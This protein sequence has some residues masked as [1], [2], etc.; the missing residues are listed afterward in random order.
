MM[1]FHWTQLLPP[2]PVTTRHGGSEQLGPRGCPFPPL[3][4]PLPFSQKGGRGSSWGSSALSQAVR[5]AGSH[6]VGGGHERLTHTPRTQRDGRV[7]L[8]SNLKITSR[9]LA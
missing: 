3:K 5:G 7:E 6:G 8:P 1:G 2:K 4:P 9:P